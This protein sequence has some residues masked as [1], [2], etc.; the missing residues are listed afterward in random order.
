MNPMKW[1]Y[2]V[3]GYHTHVQVFLNGAYIGSLTFRNEDFAWVITRASA[4]LLANSDD[5][6][7]VIEEVKPLANPVLTGEPIKG[8][9]CQHHSNK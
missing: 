8:K 9:I 2:R 4:A 7:I 6:A 1:Q 5:P 3:K